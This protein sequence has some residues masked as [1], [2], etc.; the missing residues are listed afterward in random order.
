MSI[1]DRF[2]KKTP[3]VDLSILPDQFVTVDIETTG[4][5]ADRHLIIEIAAIRIVKGQNTHRALNHLVK[6]PAKKRVPQKITAMTGITTDMI[7]KDGQPIEWVMKEFKEFIGDLRLVIYNAPFDMS[8]LHK[9]A[10][11]A[12]FKI[13]NPVS[14]A[15]DMAR[16]TFPNAP[17]HRL[18]T[19]AKAA[20][21]D[22]AGAHR[23]LQDCSLTARVYGMAVLRLGCIS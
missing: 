8:F 23:A 7:K 21:F 6:L 4:L 3:E 1:F 11:E 16:R 14:C 17:N 2:R 22:T 18:T 15:L 13:N 5:S 9:A 10:L 20:G 19:I 12:G